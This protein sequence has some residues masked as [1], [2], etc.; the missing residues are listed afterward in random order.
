MTRRDR[1]PFHATET[2]RA[3]RIREAIEREEALRARGVDPLK[4]ARGARRTTPRP[5]RWKRNLV[6]ILLVVLLSGCTGSWLLWQRV[7]AFNDAVSSAGSLSSSLLFPLWG[8]ER[9]NVAMYGYGGPEHTGGTYLAD[10]I[11]I[12][13]IDPKTDTTTMIPIPRDLWIEGLTEMPNGKVNEA[14]ADGF[15]RGGVREAGTLATDVLTK[16]T[17]LKIEHWMALDFT[18]FKAMIDAVGGVTVDNP[19]AFQYTWEEG[20]FFAG[21]WDGG[22]FAAGPIFLDGVHALDYSRSRYNSVKA[23]STDFARSVRQQRVLVAL[24]AKLGGGGIGA[25]GPGLAIMDSL[26]GLMATDLSA[27]DL[28]L[29]SSHLGADRRL[30][31]SEGVILEATFNSRGQYVFVVIGRASGTDYAP[32]QAYIQ[33]EL[34]RPL[35]TPVPSPSPSQ[36]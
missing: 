5:R 35:P 14:F 9:V 12:L 25:L 16:I 23:E 24:R 11:I 19:V 32:L 3:R 15:V 7:A 28:Y 2:P 22:S 20:K 17:G 10:S 30:E 33:T 6:L 31:L 36:P 27:I 8:S 34:A 29:L 1:R 21:I 13:S 26:K 18:G 4:P